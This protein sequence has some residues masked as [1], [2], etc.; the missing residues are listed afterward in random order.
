MNNLNEKNI[1][2]I[3]EMGMLQRAREEEMEKREMH[4]LRKVRKWSESWCTRLKGRAECLQ[5]HDFFC[6]FF[7]FFT[8]E[9]DKLSSAHQNKDSEKSITDRSKSN[10][11]NTFINSSE[12]H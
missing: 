7:V 4:E 6:V 12:G 8:P 5:L 3:E 1:N 10:H 11:F 2:Y 9:K